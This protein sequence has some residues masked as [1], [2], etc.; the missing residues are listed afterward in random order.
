MKS[1]DRMILL[2]VLGVLAIGAVWFG[3][4]SPKRSELSQLDSELATAQ[5]ALAEQEQIAAAAQA[6]QQGYEGDY[7]RLVSLGKAVPGDDDAAS[8]IEQVDVLAKRTG[9]VFSGLKLSDTGEEVAA[10]TPP[11]E[12]E[13]P[14]PPADGATPVT[15]PATETAAATAPLGAS[16][17]EAGLPVMPY[18]LTFSGTFFDIA[19]FMASLDRMVQV[20]GK[21]LAVNGRLLT[22]DGFSLAPDPSKGFP[23]LTASLHVT[24]F[25]APADQGL[26]GGA[27]P[28]TP[29][30]AATPATAPATTPTSPA[31]TAAVTP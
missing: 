20:G 5:S 10:P 16:V 28:A 11:A 4:I 8:L 26:T 19:D 23:T 2:G 6:A 17:G 1:S 29:D 24:T 25:V 18:D 7:K 30:P 22:V 13:S 15:A 12:T 9:V 3:L 21:S 27:T 14:E 31:P